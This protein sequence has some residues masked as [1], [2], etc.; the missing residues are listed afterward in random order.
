[1]KTWVTARYEDGEVTVSVRGAATYGK[2]GEERT[3]TA[4]VDIPAGDEGARDLAALLGDLAARF[5]GDLRNELQIEQA[6]ALVAARDRR[7][8]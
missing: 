4:G 6:R 7:E 1:M 5:E 2:K 3:V 8:V